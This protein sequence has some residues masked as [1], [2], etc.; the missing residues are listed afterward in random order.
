M[1]KVCGLAI[2]F[3]GL[4]GLPYL[5]HVEPASRA[6]PGADLRSVDAPILAVPAGGMAPD[7][8]IKAYD[9]RPLRDLGLDGT[10]ETVVVTIPRGGYRQANLDTFTSKYGLPPIELDP[11]PRLGDPLTTPVGS[12][13]LE[14]DL[15]V[16]HAIAPGARLV[17]YNLTA[18][19][20]DMSEML[21]PVIRD[22][23]NSIISQSWG[24]CETRVTPAILDVIAAKFEK[25]A[26]RGSASSPRRATAAATTA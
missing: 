4:L 3:I 20:T 19:T 25:A 23:P 17:V 14:M 26:G 11:V 16:I 1:R 24:F 8:L 9:I 12:G 15:E 21:D 5:P 22:N 2:C 7:D 10:G 18:P 13:E 6:D